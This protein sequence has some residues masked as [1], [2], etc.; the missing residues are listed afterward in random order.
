[1]ARLLRMPE[2]AANAHDAVLQAWTVPENTTFSAEDA[3]AAVE[4][5][6]A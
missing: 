3:V 4:T 6:K 1:M 5:D 2:V